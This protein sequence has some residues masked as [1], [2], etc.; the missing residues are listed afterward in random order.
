M[1]RDL[2]HNNNHDM[3]KDIAYICVRN[4]L[5]KVPVAGIMN[6]DH[7]H[8]YQPPQD[9]I[10]RCRDGYIL[11]FIFLNEINICTLTSGFTAC[12]VNRYTS[13]IILNV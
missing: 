6:K 5:Y 3:G 9:Q 11:D 12:V 8:L 10:Y 1:K 4:K 2:E 13:E 7:R